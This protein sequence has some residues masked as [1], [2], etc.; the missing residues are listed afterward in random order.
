LWFGITALVFGVLA[1]VFWDFI[2]ET[3]VIPLY[4]FFWII[5]LTVKSVPDGVYLAVL[6]L[7]GFMLSVNALQGLQLR[8]PNRP[9]TS[10][11]YSAS[12]RYTVWARLYRNLYR[13]TILSNHFG[14]ETRRLLLTMLAYQE[15]VTVEEA[16]A[17]VKSGA[18]SV[19][20]AVKTLVERKEI[21]LNRPQNGANTHW[22][23][24]WL[25]PGEPA[26]D[27]TEIDPQVA[28]IV[29]FIEHRLEI[30]HDQPR[31]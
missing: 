8:G 26:L 22:L 15:N 6:L 2:R 1:L 13:R 10:A 16:E 11:P 12:T 4:H 7:I 20:P 23:L 18:L 31:P 28:E 14:S 5:D 9:P 24:R 30:T 3:I 25:R 19:P 17:L 21:H 27:S 29:A